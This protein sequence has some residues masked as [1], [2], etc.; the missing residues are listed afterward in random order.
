MGCFVVTTNF[1]IKNDDENMLCTRISS[2]YIYV[3]VSRCFRLNK[4]MLAQPFVSALSTANRFRM[5][6]SHFI[7]NQVKRDH[8]KFSQLWV[9]YVAATN[10]C[11]SI[12]FFSSVHPFHALF[13]L[14]FSTFVYRH[15]LTF[16]WLSIS[17]QYF[18]HKIQSLEHEQSRAYA[19]S[20]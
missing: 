20:Y 2:M 6:T 8:L 9:R 11:Q 15:T 16:N 14:K 7:V 17:I 5:Q 10:C 18:V 3:C 12:S 13:S 1:S 19:Q 4:I